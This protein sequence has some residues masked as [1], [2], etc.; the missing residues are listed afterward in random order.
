MARS[1]YT[2]RSRI[3]LEKKHRPVS[4]SGKPAFPAQDLDLLPNLQETIWTF[5]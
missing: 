2:E 1:G 3:S 4:T 5:Y